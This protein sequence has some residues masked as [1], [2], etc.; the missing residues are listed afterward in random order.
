M[1]STKAASRYAKALLELAIE[2]NKV[3]AI[4]KD[5]HHLASVCAENPDFIKFLNSPVVRADKKISI[6]SEIFG[7]FDK[8]TTLFV[9]LIFT[10]RREFLFA[11][12]AHSFN[13]QMKAHKGIVPMTITSASPLAAST[14]ES[15]LSKIRGSVKGE[16]EITEEIDPELIGGFI[17][18]MGD[19]QIDASISNQLNNLKQRLTK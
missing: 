18:R 14:K 6:F 8:I 7:Q 9:N 17:V 12:I 5:M 11:E 1:K 13:D 19:T 15:I 2:N 16:L 10:N 3:D 4:A